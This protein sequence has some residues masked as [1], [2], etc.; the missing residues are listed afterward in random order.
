MKG[1]RSAAAG[2]EANVKLR[3]Y[4]FGVICA[5]Y[6]ITAKGE[7]TAGAGT[8]ALY[9]GHDYLIGV[10]KGVTDVLAYFPLLYSCLL[11]PSCRLC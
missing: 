5:V 3:Q 7:L 2:G 4:K 9:R 1:E 8:A 6:Q 11:Y 10:C